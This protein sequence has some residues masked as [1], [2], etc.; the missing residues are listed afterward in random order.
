[1]KS[2]ISNRESAQEEAREREA[3]PPVSPDPPPPFDA[4]GRVGED[5]AAGD[6]TA[7]PQTSRKSG[8][9][10]SAQKAARARATEQ[11]LPASQKVAGAF[12][13]EPGEPADR[14]TLGRIGHR[15]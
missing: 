15:R 4:A 10:S 6:G 3:Y 13:R 5:G 9:R 14:D 12:G 8:S 2:G 11:P 7:S 1:M